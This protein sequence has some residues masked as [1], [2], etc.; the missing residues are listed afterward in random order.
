MK[1][2][3]A[4]LALTALVGGQVSAQGSLRSKIASFGAMEPLSAADVQGKAEAWLKDAGKNDAATLERVR[5]VWKI[6]DRTVLDRLVD[7]F[8]LGSADAAKLMEE[9]RTPLA[10]A[11]VD[12]PGIL[13]DEKQPAFFRANLALAYA[14]SLNGRR[15]H[16]EA[17]AALKLF[18][19]EQVIDPASYLFHRAIAEHSMLMKKEA[20]TT[21][22]RL[23]DDVSGV[24]ERYKTVS[25]LML[26]DMQT[27]KDKDLGSVARK[28]DN[29]ERRLDLARGG[30][31]TQ[32][33]QKEIVARLD[34]LIKEMENKK[35]GGGGGGGGGG[36]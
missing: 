8:A 36:S 35:K 3:V 17:L 29:V 32:K 12:V 6:E 21:I 20:T 5:A 25:A 7:T 13:K 10:D 28:M 27:W 34:E 11:P 31:Q 26:L 30:P 22:T 4:A 14:R 15:I 1:S 16:E 33:L 9:A 23:L 24:A 18:T 2:L 19:A